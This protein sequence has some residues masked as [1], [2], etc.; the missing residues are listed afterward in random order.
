VTGGKAMEYTIDK[1]A[2][3]AGISSRT[4]RYYDEIGIL[5]PNRINSSGYRIYGRQE[6]DKLQLILFYKHLGVKLEVIKEI[7]DSPDSDEIEAPKN[8]YR[9]LL[10]KRKQLDALIENVIKTIA[11]KEGRIIM[12]DME[13]FEGFKKKLI[14]ENEKKYGKEIREKYGEETV[15]ESNRKFM[16]M[17]PEQYE[18]VSKLER[19][20][21]ETLYEAMKTGDPGG[22]IAQKA[23]ELHKEWLCCFWHNY[24]KEAHAGIVQMY[25]NDERFRAYYD[26]V[27]PG[28]AEF[29]RDAVLIFT[30]MKG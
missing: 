27:Q 30:G 16:E 29:L 3:L 9:E 20:I 23:A 1:L 21:M 15:N 28:T 4:L 7:L 25:V 24:S 2:K 17:T 26:K 10:E 14:D 13:K 18:K 8:H 12:N 6:I 11:E 5:K 22:E 19:E